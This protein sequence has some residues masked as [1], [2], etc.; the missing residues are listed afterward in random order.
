MEIRVFIGGE[1]QRWATALLWGEEPGGIK[2]NFLILVKDTNTLKQ[3]NMLK[4]GLLP[5]SEAYD[6]NLAIFD[7]LKQ[8]WN[9]S[10]L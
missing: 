8:S 9:H 4:Q 3:K 5:E 10:I 1:G 7:F 6:L 2:V